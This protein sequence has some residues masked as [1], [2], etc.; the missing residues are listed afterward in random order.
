MVKII[1][2][3]G[4]V[5]LVAMLALW[6]SPAGAQNNGSLT[7]PSAMF[8]PPPETGDGAPNAFGLQ[9]QWTVFHASQWTPW[10]QTAGPGYVGGTG[11]IHPST[12]GYNGY[13]TQVFLP[14]GASVGTVCWLT[15]DND[16]AGNWVVL[17]FHA[18]ESSY[19]GATPG[20]YYTSFDQ[21]S[22]DYAGQPEYEV[23]CRS[24][25]SVMIRQ[26]GDLNSDGSTHYLSY[27][28][29][30]E[31]TNAGGNQTLRFFG[32]VVIWTRVISPAPGVAT[33]PDVAPGFWAFQEIEA[34]AASGITTG[35]PDG[36]FRPTATVTRAQM[37]TF[38]ARALGLHWPQ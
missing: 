34:L 25:P 15:Y 35:F 7:P 6:S 28:L 3:I 29:S 18:Y 20:A 23:L 9:L 32:A 2:R 21:G 37:A 4:C 5:L 10:N 38:L 31:T 17:D 8:A 27:N 14:S 16:A 12:A 13:W 26:Y 1:S 30:A 11:Y 22:T 36:T 19:W 24:F 33:F